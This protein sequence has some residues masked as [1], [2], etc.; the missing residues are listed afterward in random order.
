MQH[1]NELP[2]N[3]TLIFPTRQ[4][5]LRAHLAVYGPKYTELAK[6]LDI[7]V[8]TATELC[9]R[10]TAAPLRVEQMKELGIPEELLPTPVYVKPGRKPNRVSEEAGPQGYDA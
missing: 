9:Q 3:F 5:A 7:S 4:Q 8:R 10:E 6:E 2:S 1:Q